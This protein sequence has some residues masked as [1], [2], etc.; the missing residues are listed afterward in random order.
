MLSSKQCA[1]HRRAVHSQD[2]DKLVSPLSVYQPAPLDLFSQ[3][4]LKEKLAWREGAQRRIVSS[5]DAADRA[6]S[7]RAYLCDVLRGLDPI[8]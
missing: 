7:D 6:R 3:D 1:F 2:H 8:S 5:A 4:Q